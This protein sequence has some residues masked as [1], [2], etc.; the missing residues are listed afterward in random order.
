MRN[1]Y[2]VRGNEV[3]VFAYRKGEEFEFMFELADLDFLRS[4]DRKFTVVQS[5]GEGVYLGYCKGGKHYLVHRVLMDAPEGLFVDHIDQNT[6]N[7]KR[8]N[9]RLLTVSESNQ[10]KR[11][12]TNTGER[13]INKR[14]LKTT[15]N[16]KVYEYERFV[17]ELYDIEKGRRTF[18]KSF[19]TLEEAVQ[20]RDEYMKKEG[21][22]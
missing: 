21:L 19:K 7:M 9:L 5:R 10:N 18:T 11:V 16:G 6:R 17:F 2:E 22:S 4:I 13:Q 20:F 3:I 1:Q 8:S 15:K 14:I 12:M